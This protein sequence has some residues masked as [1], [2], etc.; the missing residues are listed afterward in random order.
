M[1]RRAL[2]SD[3]AEESRASPSA[4]PRKKSRA[5]AH[6]LRARRWCFTYHLQRDP[7]EKGG[8]LDGAEPQREGEEAGEP[9]QSAERCDSDKEEESSLSQASRAEENG[10]RVFESASEVGEHFRLLVKQC[11]YF[12]AQDEQCPT[13]KR[14]HVQGY[15]RMSC[16]IPL[17]TM[18]KH[19]PGAHFELCKGDEASNIRYC[20]KEASRIEGGVPFTFGEVAEQGKRSDIVRAREIIKEGGGMR[21]VCEEV[22]SYQATKGAELLL[23]YIEKGRDFKPEVRWYYGSTGSGKTRAAHDEFPDAWISGKSLKWFE[24]YDAHQ[25]VI[26]DDFR[27]DFCTFHELLR[28]LDRYPFR[29]ETKGGSRQLLAKVIIITCPWEPAVLYSTRQAEDIQQL[30]RRIDVVKLFG[31]IVPPPVLFVSRVD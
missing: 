22:S 8:R 10:E 23:K 15:V 21:Q 30:L 25:V 9:R 16:Q 18:K 5:S 7:R 27:K 12:I 17:S 31:Q 24:G 3:E 4:P 1:P 19:L 26:V 14:F 2:V 29:V 6:G 20:S 11:I 13:T 28:I